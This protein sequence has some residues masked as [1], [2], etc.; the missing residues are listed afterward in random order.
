M[1]EKI[2][3][4]IKNIGFLGALNGSSFKIKVISILVLTSILSVGVTVYFSS[5]SIKDEGVNSLVSKSKTILSRVEVV[6]DYVS[7]Q[8]YL[9][10]L[11]NDAKAKFPGGKI[12]KSYKE[13]ILKSVP[14]FAAWKVANTDTKK[15][16]YSFSIFA[17]N[18]RNK[19]NKATPEQVKI[20]KKFKDKEI[21]MWVDVDEDAGVVRVAKPVF[22]KKADGCLNCHGTKASSPWGNGKDVLGYPMENWVDGQ[23]H[24]AFLVESSLAPVIAATNDASQKIILFGFLFS[25]LFIFVGNLIVNG[26]TKDLSTVNSGVSN[27]SNQINSTSEK[28][29]SSTETLSGS[30]INQVAAIEETSCS[31]N[32]MSDMIQETTKSIEQSVKLTQAVEDKSESGQQ[33]MNSLENSMDSIHQT[34][35]QLEKIANIIEDITEKAKVINDISFQTKI[36]SFNTSIEAARA[37]KY[38]SGF[39][40][41]AEEVANLAQ[42]SGN[43]ADEI[44]ELFK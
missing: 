23:I 44:Q 21:D 17:E 41:I 32:Q 6:R 8:G 38:G 1:K 29:I 16:M 25:V 33:I 3:G 42:S 36:L 10:E 35:E 30:T 24:G 4:S 2:A 19:D 37:G 12:S 5:Q 18:A 28:L 43:A 15:D 40:V 34:N 39:T 9:Q 11:I 31:M 26:I 20:L 27:Q 13:R 14:I 22:I 7:K